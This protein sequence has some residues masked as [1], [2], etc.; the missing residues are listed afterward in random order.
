M[1]TLTVNNSRESNKITVEDNF[2]FIYTF[3]L[4]FGVFANTTPSL[5]DSGLSMTRPK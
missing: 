4:V 5:F 1:L 3:Y 2:Y